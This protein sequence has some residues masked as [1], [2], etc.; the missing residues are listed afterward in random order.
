MSGRRGPAERSAGPRIPP[1]LHQVWFGPLPA[2]LAWTSTWERGNPNWQYRLWDED[3]VAQLGLHNAALWRELIRR[4]I[5]DAASDVARVEILYRF[6]GVYADADSRCLR[7]LDGA[8]FLRSGFFATEEIKPDGETFVTNAFMGSEPHHPILSSYIERIARRRRFR[9]AHGGDGAGF[10]CAWRLTGPIQLT[11]ILRDAT[12]YEVLPPSAF[13]TR[14]L[15]GEPVPGKGWG[16]HYWS[17]TGGRSPR[18]A[19]PGSRNYQEATE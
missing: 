7:S 19:F 3:S 12:D 5:Y 6:G 9:C 14:T 16:E 15:S 17:S 13:F 1:L 11:R 8:A 4:G 18:D 2:P 10:C